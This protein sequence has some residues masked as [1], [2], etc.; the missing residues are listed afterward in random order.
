MSP[1]LLELSGHGGGGGGS[2]GG[3]F[4]SDGGDADDAGSGEGSGADAGEDFGCFL[5]DTCFL[6]DLG[7]VVPGGGGWKVFPLAAQM[8]WVCCLASLMAAASLASEVPASS[9]SPSYLKSGL[10]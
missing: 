4:G 6:G 5:G 10:G 2:S 8:A 7:A 3:G 1:L 9:V